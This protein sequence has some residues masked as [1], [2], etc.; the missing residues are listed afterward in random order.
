MLFQLTHA[1]EIVACMRMRSWVTICYIWVLSVMSG[2]QCMWINN[3]SCQYNPQ[4]PLVC[5]Y[6]SRT[7]IFMY[8]CMHTFTEQVHRMCRRRASNVHIQSQLSTTSNIGV[9]ITC[10]RSVEIL[11]NIQAH[12]KW[13]WRCE[14][15]RVG[16]AVCLHSPASES[17]S[18]QNTLTGEEG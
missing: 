7:S 15:E 14:K 16:Y 4:W 2:R 9:Q 6:K 17:S 10:N 18:S 8:A 11:H 13:N 5:S 3:C 1:G 12:T